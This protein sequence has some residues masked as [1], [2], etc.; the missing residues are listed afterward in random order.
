MFLQKESYIGLA[1][2]NFRRLAY[3]ET[4]KPVEYRGN[5]GRAYAVRSNACVQH[6]VGRQPLHLNK[7]IGDV[8][9]FLKVSFPHPDNKAA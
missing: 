1:T 4:R 9:G 3:I 5:L 2:A 8:R 6:V 7:P